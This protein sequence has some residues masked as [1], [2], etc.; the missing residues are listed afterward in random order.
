MREKLII[1]GIYIFD[2]VSVV[3][4]SAFCFPTGGE[5]K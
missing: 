4:I 3:L 2:I 1:L 5:K